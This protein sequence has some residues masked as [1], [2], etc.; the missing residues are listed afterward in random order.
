MCMLVK[1]LGGR[2]GKKGTHGIDAPFVGHGGLAVTVVL[3]K[4]EQVAVFKDRDVHG[5]DRVEL[6]GG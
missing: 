5:G 4:G 1:A 3:V 2:E 6:S